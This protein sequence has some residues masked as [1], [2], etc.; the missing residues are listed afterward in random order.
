MG[1]LEL[2][3]LTP[4]DSSPTVALFHRRASIYLDLLQILLAAQLQSPKRGSEEKSHIADAILASTVY[5]PTESESSEGPAWSNVEISR[6]AQEA[7]LLAG[8]QMMGTSAARQ[9]GAESQL[10]GSLEQSPLPTLTSSKSE[11]VPM[12]SVLLAHLASLLSNLHP[13]LRTKAPG[14]DEA[15]FGGTQEA[16]RGAAVLA[17]HQLSFIVR[18]I[19]FPALGPVINKA[20][21]S[22][23]TAV[24]HW[25]PPVKKQGLQALAHIVENV[26]VAELSWFGE[27]VMDALCKTAVGC[28]EEVWPVA[29]P[30]LVK[31]SVKIAGKDPRQ[32]W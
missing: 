8:K 13:I 21:P 9:P 29:L 11:R 16:P 2:G 23:L 28:D 26:T 7:I 5:C 20:M 25:A 17:A 31:A 19:S 27:V 12:Q 4:P 24:D 32:K 22:V 10:R 18:S 15:S 30:T 3:T 1:P 6:K 14:S